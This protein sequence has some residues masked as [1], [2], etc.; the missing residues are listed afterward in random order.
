MAKHEHSQL[1]ATPAGEGAPHVGTAGLFRPCPRA[2][3][4]CLFLLVGAFAGSAGAIHI[5]PVLIVGQPV[6]P[7][8]AGKGT[9][10]CAAYRVTDPMDPL[11]VFGVEEQA[12]DPALFP[13]RVNT[14]MDAGGGARPKDRATATVAKGFDFSNRAAGSAGDFAGSADRCM[15]PKCKFT[16]TLPD[17]A[18]LTFKE[19][20]G[21]RFRG[22]L[23]VTADLVDVPI[24]FGFFVDDAVALVIYDKDR[25]AHYVVSRGPTL[26][27][28]QWRVTNQVRFKN[29]GLY[30]IEVL[31]AQIVEAAVLEWAMLLDPMG[32]FKDFERSVGDPNASR[33]LSQSG[34]VLM[35]PVR[36]FQTSNGMLPYS[37]ANRC[38]QCPRK[39]ANAPGGG[40]TVGCSDVDHFCN[41]AAV[42]APCR[43]KEHCG[44]LCNRCGADRPICADV[45]GVQECVECVTDADC[46]ADQ[47]CSS[48]SHKCEVGSGKLGVGSPGGAQGCRAAPAGSS[49]LPDAGEG[50]R[51]Q[52]YV[53]A[54]LLLIPLLLWLAR[55]R[56]GC[57]HAPADRSASA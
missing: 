23:N 48:D 45:D 5:H 39:F 16:A 8:L 30:P 10:L 40:P 34:F 1:L 14:F 20:F 9:G 50:A 18:G 17:G 44:S 33:S 52:E 19:D 36:F 7:P 47:Y 28:P 46:G 12:A 49:A 11:D 53:W 21:G 29:A 57:A 3:A 37:D 25:T 35:P 32:V 24:H 42:C 6:A 38:E 54:G 31:Y 13:D 15:P 26:G 22:F 2:T 27:S 56:R 4:V 41:D 55:R 51:W 43:E